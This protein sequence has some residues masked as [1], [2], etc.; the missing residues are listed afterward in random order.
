V[1]LTRLRHDLAARAAIGARAARMAAI[2][3]CGLTVVDLTIH[4]PRQNPIVPAGDWLA[5]PRS[6]DLIRADT[7]QPRTF[8]PRHRELHRAA[9]QRARG[10]VDVTPYFELRDVLQPNLGGPLWNVPSADCYAGISASWYVNVWADHNRENGFMNA[11]TSI[12]F[13]AGVLRTHP[14]LPTVLSAY[15]VTHVLSAYPQEGSSLSFAGRGG[16][17]YVYR[18]AGS[19][20]VRVV[21]SARAVT[22]DRE[23]ARGI[24]DAA[25]DPNLIVFLH[26]AAPADVS[27]V[28]TDSG[29]PAPAPGRA[30]ITQDSG[31]E[32]VIEAEAIQDA[33]LLLADTYYPG[34][35]ARIDGVPTPIYRAN[36]SVRAIRLPK[37]KHEVRF[38]YV[39]PRFAA[40]V[41]ISGLSLAALLLWIGGA[42]GYL[43]RDD[44]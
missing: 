21:G 32:I 1:G 37:G 42:A 26:D 38:S 25:F 10:W 40:G 7:A 17:G 39:L 22:D 6:V 12:D 41:R 36:V 9:F 13:G 29:A 30:A 18:V 28:A 23:A 14:R 24:L 33:F 20:R 3:L 27:S 4:Q 2:A 5:P 11:L 34:W 19:A 16:T 8:T 44:D 31:T 15:G 35:T 43:M